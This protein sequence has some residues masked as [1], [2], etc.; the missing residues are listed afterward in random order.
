MI[1]GVTDNLKGGAPGAVGKKILYSVGRG[2]FVLFSKK[3]IQPRPQKIMDR[4]ATSRTRL[5]AG[6]AT[7][8]DPPATENE[9]RDHILGV[10]RGKLDQRKDIELIP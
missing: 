5:S 10:L 9:L 1:Q 7:T 8:A 4:Q 2:Q 6:P 3:D